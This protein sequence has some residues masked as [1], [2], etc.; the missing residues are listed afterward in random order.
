MMV[1]RGKQE[2]EGKREKGNEEG[3]E[4]EK[5]NEVVI[6][7]D[8]EEKRERERERDREREREGQHHPFPSSLSHTVKTM[9]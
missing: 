6:G 7:K 3:C 9:G 2:N 1:Q 5:M 4:D 8:G